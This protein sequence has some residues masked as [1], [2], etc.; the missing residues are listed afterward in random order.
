MT[1]RLLIIDAHNY[2]FRAYHAIAGLR[3]RDGMATNAVYGLAISFSALRESYPDAAVAAVMD[4]PGKTF[5]HDLF[6]DYKANRPEIEEDLRVQI[7]PS[8]ELVAAMGMQLYCVPGVEADDVIASAAIAA[9][10][11][12]AQVVIASSDKDLMYLAGRGAR[13]HDPKHNVLLDAAAVAQ[14]YGVQPEQM[15]DY[16]AL[17]GDSSDNVP[18]V[19]G[20]GPKRARDLLSE[21]K[22]LDQIIE[23]ADQ[24][25]GKMGDNLRASLA[26]LP[27]IRKLVAVREDIAL[28]PPVEQLAAPKLQTERME[29][30][31]AKMRF[32]PDL[33]ARLLARPAALAERR[34]L[35]LAIISS[36]EQAK[37]A[38]EFIGKAGALGAHIESEGSDPR[39][40]RMIGLAIA[41]A[42][43]GWYLPL[44]H[45]GELLAPKATCA[46]LDILLAAAAESGERLAVFAAKNA[47][48]CL[49]EH[50]CQLNNCADAQLLS[51]SID[52][53]ASG[54]LA[55]QLRRHDLPPV[56]DAARLLGKGKKSSLA[57]AQLD[58]ETAANAA[59]GWAAA[60]A[61]L[62]K[63]LMMSA[64]AAQ[65]DI[66]DRIER[67][68]LPVLVRMERAGIMIDRTRLARLSEQLL[69][70][71]DASQQKIAA[72]AGEQLN[73]N[74]PAQ[75]SELLYGKLGL[76]AGRKTSQGKFSTNETELERLAK[77]GKSP[78]PGWIL[79]YRQAAK[80]HGTYTAAL[81]KRINPQTGRIHTTFIQS[82][83]VT[84]RLAS[85]DPN[86]Q[87]IPVRTEVGQAIRRSFICAPGTLLV[88]ADYSQIELRILAHF[89]GETT[90]I[91]AFAAGQDIH[92]RTAAE[93]FAVPPDKVSA[94]QR[95]FAKTIN[96]GLI[97][98]MSAFGLAQR[99]MVSRAKAGE[100]IERYFA[101]LPKVSAYLEE[102]KKQAAQQRWVETV[103]R[104]RISATP[105]AGTAASR[106][107]ALRAAINAP[108][109]GSAADIMKLAMIEVDRRLAA[110]GFQTRMLLQV[111]D[112]LVLE[113]PE[114]EVE[115]L[116]RMLPA[117][118]TGVCELKVPLAVDIGVGRNWD[119]A[120]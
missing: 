54:N 21:Y 41:T 48:H 46:A 47:I 91:E 19:P 18:G 27:L 50:G 22:S 59:L 51:Y 6:A 84:G 55:G 35:P 110:E 95:R 61:G 120:H 96:F 26:D 52:S 97:Y 28:N 100:L 64:T 114:D 111:H 71:M 89:S 81:P 68:L 119:A 44:E 92:S 7:E 87:N 56:E 23:Q 116:S 33:Q 67:P 104:R 11:R 17:V 93:I 10:G 31:C 45:G 63:K 90:L 115:R 5:R 32:N 74:S 53:S 94:D 113:A 36:A 42:E 43:R 78:V 38:A 62:K 99:L 88:S 49:H 108:M 57:F 24:V 79:E 29:R 60:A 70:R 117:A 112:E 106:S 77:T 102:L 1:E 8:K 72:A 80:L 30:L 73:L 40:R 16:L 83:A 98:G 9:A 2:L 101:R 34:K 103:C 12:G 109:Q 13:I 105:T 15:A 86:L 65:L 76:T 14:R 25:K 37:A 107:H 58:T 4:A 82:G 20:I 85:I 3:S 66:Y 118:M 75:L 69:A 39:C